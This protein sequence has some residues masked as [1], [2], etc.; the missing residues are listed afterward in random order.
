MWAHLPLLYCLFGV[1]I[2]I[3]VLWPCYVTGATEILKA[4]SEKGSFQNI[5][6]LSSSICSFLLFLP[7]CRRVCKAIILLL[8]SLSVWGSLWEKQ[9]KYQMCSSSGCWKAVILGIV[10]RK[11][12]TSIA[13][14]LATQVRQH[15]PGQK[16]KIWSVLPRFLLWYTWT[17]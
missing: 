12:S 4:T 17:K 11:S 14:P 9:E 16:F 6:E 3:P 5:S 13:P 15:N 2:S 10:G 8:A 1:H 7:F